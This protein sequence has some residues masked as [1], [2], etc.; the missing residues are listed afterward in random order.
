MSDDDAPELTAASFEN[1]QWYCN[2]RPATREQVVMWA[3]E[4]APRIVMSQLERIAALTARCEALEARLQ[5]LR[6]RVPAVLEGIDKTESADKAGWWET[7][8]GAEFGAGVLAGIMALIDQPDADG[9][10]A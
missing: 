9:G 8:T 7:S 1:G 10:G 6:V 5:Q 4:N 3:R 2:G